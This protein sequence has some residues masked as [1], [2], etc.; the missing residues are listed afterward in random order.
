MVM[1][2]QKTWVLVGVVA[3]AVLIG[4]TAG[5]VWASSQSER[6][7]VTAVVAIGP[8]VSLID[9]GST[10]DVIDSI[11]RGTIAA[12]TA[13]IATSSSVK[14]AA[15]TA[16]G[17]DDAGDYEIDAL[18]VLSSS[19]V[20]IIVSGPDPDMTAALANEVAAGLATSVSEIY[21]VYRVELVNAAE[22]P[23]SSSRP[24]VGLPMLAAGLFAGAGAAALWWA[25]FGGR[26]R[27]E[28]SR[29]DAA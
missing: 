8:S 19:L 20:D 9:E 11:D 6:Y 27:A 18:P 12:T 23:R 26:W 21:D 14:R 25:I 4:M 3:I 13:G 28:R 16:A 22:A 17:L 24:G 1:R 5:G 2:G 10:I 15:A 7:E 29:P